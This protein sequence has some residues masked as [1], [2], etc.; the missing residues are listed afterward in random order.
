MSENN[1]LD[2]LSEKSLRCVF[3]WKRI[4]QNSPKIPLGV[5]ICESLVSK[6]MSNS[7]LIYNYSSD[8]L[9]S[10]RYNLSPENTLE[11]YDCWYLRRT[12]VKRAF[13]QFPRIW[14]DRDYDKSQ[15]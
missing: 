3:G 14:S 9:N 10:L 7:I 2:N 8:I 13:I 6:Q 5:A 1:Q 12:H 11:H 15:I 4:R